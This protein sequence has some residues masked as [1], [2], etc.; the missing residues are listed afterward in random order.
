MNQLQYFWV[1]KM[2]RWLIYILGIQFLAMGIICNTRTGLGVAAFTSL[3]YALSEIY[4]ISLGMG[5]I[6]LYFILIIIQI[7]LLRKLT[8]SVV[9]QIPFSFV[10]GYITDFYDYFIPFHHLTIYQ[11]FLLLMVGFVLTSLG[12]YMT[13]QCNI[14]VTPVEGIVNT[15]SQV[16]EIDFS[17]VKNMFDVSMVCL[18]IMMCLILRKPIIGIGIGTIL[19]AL[20][21]GR[22]IS[23]YQ[24]KFVLFKKE[25]V[26]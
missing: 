7:I 13:V 11:S 10:F 3:F 6:L 16:F 17:L 23:I 2:K 22:M 5:S 19:S 25:F 18:T 21:I 4:N 14:V 9:M 1:I 20:F 24:K 26:I 8:L 12:V 15:I